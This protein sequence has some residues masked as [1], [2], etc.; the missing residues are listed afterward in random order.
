M[1]LFTWI[2]CL[3]SLGS[4]EIIVCT[5]Y[6]STSQILDDADEQSH[7]TRISCNTRAPNDDVHVGPKA[8]H[9]VPAADTT[10]SLHTIVCQL[11]SLVQVIGPSKV[12]A[13]IIF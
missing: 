5:L 1:G 8:A 7:D 13:D 4:G 10:I 9:S 11:S 2:V 6:L 12:L 3:T